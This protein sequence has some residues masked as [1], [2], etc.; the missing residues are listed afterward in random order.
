MET[1]PRLLL[2]PHDEAINQHAHSQLHISSIRT[3]R[4]TAWSFL[5]SSS[6]SAYSP[7]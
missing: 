3:D 7:K 4:Y 5:R 1:G 2:H 6:L